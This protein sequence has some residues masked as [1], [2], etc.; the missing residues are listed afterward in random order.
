[1]QRAE[2]GGGGAPSRPRVCRAR[3]WRG[4]CP[5]GGR[6]LQ[7]RRICGRGR[8]ACGCCDATAQRVIQLRLRRRRGKRPAHDATGKRLKHRFRVYHVRQRRQRRRLSGGLIKSRRRWGSGNGGAR[9]APP[10]GV[11][12]PNG[13]VAALAGHTDS[14]KDRVL[15]HDRRGCLRCQPLLFRSSDVKSRRGLRCSLLLRSDAI[16][17]RLLSE[18]VGVYKNK[19][20]G[21]AAP[22]AGQRLCAGGA[23]SVVP[24]PVRNSKQSTRN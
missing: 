4:W 22:P 18:Q 20:A 10:K 11:K 21:A 8:R 12:R 1:M 3:W 2:G 5:G 17:A 16:S 19:R 9:G 15:N 24:Q 13:A 6:G 23:R 14:E 7:S